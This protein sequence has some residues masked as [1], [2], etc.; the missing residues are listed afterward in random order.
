MNALGIFM[1]FWEKNWDADHIKYINKAADIGF[2]ILEFQAQPLLEMSKDHM[3][4]IKK[5]ADERGIELTYSLGLDPA[6]DVSSSSESIRLGGIEYL[7]RIVEKVSFMNGKIISGVSYAGW[8]TSNEV[9]DDKKALVDRSISSMKEIVK[10]AEDYGV[11][12]CV[13]AVNRFESAVINTAQEALSYIEA[14]DSKNIGVLLDTYHMNIEE[15]SIGD[16]IRLVGNK[17]TSFHT[18]ENNR[19]APGRGHLNWDEIFKALSD[20]KYQGRIVSEPFIMMGGEVGSD[21]KVWRNLID[22]PTE[23]KVDNEARFLLAFE[24]EMIQKYMQ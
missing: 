4:K 17:L 8:G 7:K 12:Y 23:E 19:T 16:A 22:D 3:L 21:I 20:I 14:V 15:K 10:T 18:G 11:I 5:E 6:Y 24:K 1:N 9:I 2:D 13:E